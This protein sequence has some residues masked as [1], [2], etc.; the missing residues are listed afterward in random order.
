MSATVLEGRCRALSCVSKPQ[1]T[2]SYLC[3]A[4]TAPQC[5]WRGPLW[6]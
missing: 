5:G 6:R 1:I 4:L 2:H 3:G